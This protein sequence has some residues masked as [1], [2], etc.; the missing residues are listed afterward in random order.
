MLVT[1]KTL[2]Q[3]TFKIDIDPDET[4][5][6]LKEKIESEKGKDAFPV[7]GQKLIYAGKILN[8]DTA[9][10]EYKIDEKNFVVVMVTKPKAVTTPAP[11]T[12]QQSNPATTTTVSSSTAPAVA[13][14]PAPAPALAPTPSPASVT[15]APTTASS[16][17]APASATQPEKPA[18]K[19]A[20]TPVAT[21]P[22]ATDSTSGDSSRS[23]LFED[24]TS[25]L[26]TG[27]SYENM[28]TEIMSMGYER[29]QVIAALRASFNNPDR[30][31]EYLLMG[32]PGDRDSQA[33][34]D[35]PP[36]VSTGAPPSSVAAAAA[37]TTASTT[38]ASPGG[39][40]LEFLRNQPQFQQMRQ[41]IQQNPSLL[42][43]LLQQ[44]GRENPQL[45]QL[46]ALGFPEGL[47][48]QA[49]FAC[50]KNEN[51]AANFLLQ[52]NFDED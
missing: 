3:Q 50:E 9:L 23:N 22:T 46:K 52:Q 48:I 11:A 1:L 6:A 5:K 31:V 33:V 35:T 24:A 42:P 17:P 30:A 45:L 25:A 21:S 15:P 32:I 39:H 14:A 29:E 51:L 41:I 27:Q 19:P 26:V 8:D 16:E 20:E 43:A 47:V 10:K 44:I 49:Y 34:V 4:V 36:A 12:T 18:E 37:T 40:P 2:Q 7:A 38:T 28:V 13:Q